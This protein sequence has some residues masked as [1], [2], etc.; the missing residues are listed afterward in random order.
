MI[1]EKCHLEMSIRSFSTEARERVQPVIT[2]LIEGIAAA[3]G[4]RAE[5]DY[6][7][8]VSPTVNDA[9]VVDFVG[10][11][12]G[13]L[14]GDRYSVLDEPLGG[15][16]DFSEVL[17]RVPGAFIF[18]SGVPAG[19]DL[20]DTSYNHSATAWFDDAPIAEAIAVYA[21]LAHESLVEL[22]G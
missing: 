10:R 22:A 14:V 13:G 16:E 20:E 19:R 8:G 18:Y 21:S 17:A 1:P 3:H 2:S 6:T 9:S 15:S 11:V 4:C 7:L 12:V 5:I